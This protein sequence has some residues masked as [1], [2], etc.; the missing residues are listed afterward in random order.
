M[1]NGFVQFKNND[2]ETIT[3]NGAL[4]FVQSGDRNLAFYGSKGRSVISDEEFERIHNEI[5]LP[6]PVANQKK[7][8]SEDEEFVLPS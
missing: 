7:N 6:V 5:G 8:D 3:T 2:G 4:S 1:N